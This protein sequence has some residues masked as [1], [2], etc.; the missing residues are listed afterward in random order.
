M[1]YH[2]HIQLGPG[3]LI[4][5]V[6]T[7][8]TETYLLTTLEVYQHFFFVVYTDIEI[9][10]HTLRSPCD[11]FTVLVAPFTDSAENTRLPPSVSFNSV[12]YSESKR[13]GSNFPKMRRSQR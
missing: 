1:H 5:S 7:S 6:P 2:Y 4:V 12:M 9:A 3:Q 13:K 10:T 8:D 11:K